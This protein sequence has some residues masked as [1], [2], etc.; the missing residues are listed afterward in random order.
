M[1]DL[2]ASEIEAILFDMDGTLVDSDKAVERAWLTWAGEY[3]VDGPTAYRLAHGAPSQYA[4]RRLFPAFDDAQIEAASAR[5]LELQYD[6]LADVVATPGALPL[7]AALKLPWA[8][9]TSADARLAKARLDAVGIEPPVLVTTDDVAEGK[10]DPAGYLLAAQLL[11]VPAASCLVVE[12]AEVGLQAARAAGA[13][14]A[15]VRGLPA[16]LPLTSLTD[17]ATFLNEG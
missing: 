8:V 12:D 11:G 15:A 17:L 4:V 2:I 9:V 3:G 5:Q 1:S 10:P 7:L 6:D 16:D 13:H 14:T